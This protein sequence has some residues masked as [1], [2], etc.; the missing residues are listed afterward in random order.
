VSNFGEIG[1]KMG[2]WG[3]NAVLGDKW[4]MMRQNIK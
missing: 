2:K 1:Q 4:L 3:K